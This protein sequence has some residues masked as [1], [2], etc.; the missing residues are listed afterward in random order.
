MRI[1]R[2]NPASISITQVL[3]LICIKN[4]FLRKNENKKYNHQWP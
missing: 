2:Y 4:S 3:N 1:E